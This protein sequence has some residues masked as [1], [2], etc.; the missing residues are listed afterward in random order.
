MRRLIAFFA[1]LSL[2][3]IGAP[4]FATDLA[5]TAANVKAGLGARTASGI[6]G[7]AVTAGQ[8][9]YK[10]A[11]SHKYMKADSNSATAEARNPT[12][13]FLNNAGA[14]QPIT[15]LTG[16][17]ITIG[18]AVTANT[19]YYASDTPGGLC[20]LADVGT[21]EY[22]TLV[23]LAVSATQIRVNFQSTGVTN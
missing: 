14:D 17:L 23:G 13:I 11:V 5:V 7:E 4:A 21:G 19:A 16:G 8:L 18:G 20:P 9:C 3:M 22:L 2:I 1:A 10:A 12:C 6:A 15:V